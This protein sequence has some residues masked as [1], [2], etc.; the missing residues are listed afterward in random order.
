MTK[1]ENKAKK[2]AALAR[3]L[4]S[5]P[6]ADSPSLLLPQFRAHV[7]GIVVWSFAAAF[8]LGWAT[9]EIS[10][11]HLDD[12]AVFSWIVYCV[13]TGVYFGLPA[14]IVGTCIIAEVARARSGPALKG[15]TSVLPQAWLRAAPACR[16]L[17][18][19]SLGTQDETAVAS[20]SHK[21]D[22]ICA[23]FLAALMLAFI[24]TGI[25]VAPLSNSCR[26]AVFLAIASL[27]VIHHF[28]LASLCRE[29]LKISVGVSIIHLFATCL[30]ILSIL[31]VVLLLAYSLP[32]AGGAFSSLVW[33]LLIVSMAA[34]GIWWARR[35]LKLGE[36]FSF[37]DSYFLAA[38]LG[39]I[40][41]L[42][43]GMPTLFLLAFATRVV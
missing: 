43:I 36:S 30:T 42:A 3:L 19:G 14:A 40:P 23:Y 18:D 9:I 29:R 5:Q 26:V 7:L 38:A 13:L 8:V 35:I 15:L 27:L 33:G 2:K 25:A 16:P 1:R 21:S 11:G 4:E 20:A 24:V 37:R 28:L 12:P 22:Q 34:S 32:N 41:V 39:N 17:P 6:A 10:I 31:G